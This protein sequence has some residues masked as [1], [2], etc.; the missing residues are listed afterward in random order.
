MKLSARLPVSLQLALGSAMGRVFY[1]LQRRER[2][3]ALRNLEICLPELSAVERTAL[4]RRHFRSVGLSVVEMGVGWFMPI[5]KLRQRVDIRGLEHLDA[6][7]AAGHGALLVTAHFT[8]IEIGVDIL[9]D[10]PHAVSSLYRP[11]RNAMMDALILRGRSRFAACQI[12]RDNV[13]M[14]I[15]RLQKNEAVL[16]MPDQ[17]YLGNQSALIPFFGEPAMTNIATSKISRISG[18]KVLPYWFRRATDERHYEV[19]ICAPLEHFPTD[20]AIA[21]TSRLVALLEERIRATPE[22]YLWVYKKFKRRPAGYADP[23]LDA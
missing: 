1:R 19:E 8:P 11:Q 21:D 7:L 10:Y 14:L 4:V 18:A 5:E 3:I 13:R 23:Y 9:E 6:A 12:P 16:Y 22:Q 17:T 15:R 20:D 2:R